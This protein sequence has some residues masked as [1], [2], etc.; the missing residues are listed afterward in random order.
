MSLNPHVKE[1]CDS[2]TKSTQTTI[3]ICQQSPKYK[4]VRINNPSSKLTQTHGIRAERQEA[5]RSQGP[6]HKDNRCALQTGAGDRRAG[7]AK[8]WEPGPS[9]DPKAWGSLGSQTTSQLGPPSP[10]GP[11]TAVR[12]ASSGI[13]SAAQG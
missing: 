13:C 5:E 3:I 1:S 9:H 8:G 7:S 10:K 2:K 11:D 12:T 4:W 6:A